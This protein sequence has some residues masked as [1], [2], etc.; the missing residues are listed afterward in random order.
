MLT[1]YPVIMAGGSGT[2]LWPMSTTSNPKQFQALL[3]DQSLFQDTVQRVQ[4]AFDGVTF[5]AP[6]VIAGRAYRDLVTAQLAAIDASPHRIILEPFG[7]NTAAVTA[8]AAAIPDDDEDALVLLL[9]SDHHMGNPDAFRRAVAAAAGPTL[10]RGL[11][12]TFGIE[13]TEPETGYGYTRRG[14]A[15]SGDLAH[16]EAFV[17]KPDLETAARY[18]ADDR[19]AWNGGIFLFS[20]AIMRQELGAHAPAILDAAERSFDQGVTESAVTTLDADAFDTCPSESIDYAVMEKTSRAAVFGPLQCGWSD[21]GSW[22]ALA[23][24]SP[25][26]QRGDVV[27]VD[28]AN[29]Y[30][31][32][33]DGTLI[34][35]VGVEDLVVVADGGTVLVARKDKVQDVKA[36]VNAL[37]RQGRFEKL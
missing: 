7:R 31:R 21:I 32:S 10:E 20:A 27:A 17:E 16:C 33:E 36:V 14:A 24:L 1:V 6:S 9:P 19:Y 12:T 11:I 3:G 37:K 26:N 8:I 28:A 29:C 5:A 15:I 34:A 25:E 13:P 23:A 35:A 30:L 2:R 18:L 4:G 22:S